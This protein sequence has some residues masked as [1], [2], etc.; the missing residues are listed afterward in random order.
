MLL[1]REKGTAKFGVPGT[2]LIQHKCICVPNLL[3]EYS[4]CCTT[5]HFLSFVM[6]HMELRSTVVMYFGSYDIGHAIL[7][8]YHVCTYVWISMKV[9]R[10]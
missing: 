9:S 4:V 7:S 1:N 10:L 8:L 2:E 3:Y 6:V 5:Y